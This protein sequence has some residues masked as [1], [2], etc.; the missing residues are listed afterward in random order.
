MVPPAE[1]KKPDAILEAWW[2]YVTTFSVNCSE[3][4]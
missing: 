3:R 4:C 1:L 2:K